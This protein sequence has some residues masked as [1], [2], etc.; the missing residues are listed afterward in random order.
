LSFLLIHIA[1]VIR[2]GW[3]NFQSIVTGFDAEDVKITE[4]EEEKIIDAA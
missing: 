3:K 4:P 2:A 1:Q